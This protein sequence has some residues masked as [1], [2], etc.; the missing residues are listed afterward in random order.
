MERW[1]GSQQQQEEEEQEEGEAAAA[2]SGGEEGCDVRVAGRG[3]GRVLPHPGRLRRSLP[4]P[5]GLPLHVG[6]HILCGSVY[7]IHTSI[8]AFKA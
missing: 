1:G 7:N 2:E 5:D 8:A 3:R 6:L 4:V